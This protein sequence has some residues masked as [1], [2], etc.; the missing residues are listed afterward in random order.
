[1]SAAA[2]F[3]QTELAD[4][5]E[6]QSPR[7]PPVSLGPMPVPMSPDASTTVEAV[8]PDTSTAS[9]SASAPA[10]MPRV[11]GTCGVPP[12]WDANIGNQTG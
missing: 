6:F 9:V 2:V 12:G 3:G 10:G 4:G 8:P 7:G 1:M 5:S 11:P